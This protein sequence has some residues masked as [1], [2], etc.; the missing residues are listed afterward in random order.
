MVLS[1]AVVEAARAGN[2]ATV[3]QWL[4]AGGDA[5]ARC[6]T[7]GKTLLHF[8]A[9]N[10]LRPDEEER[11][12]CDIARLLLARG[13]EVDAIRIHSVFLKN[14]P[15]LSASLY[16]R[17]ELCRLLLEAGADP[18]YKREE[19]DFPLWVACENPATLRVL[20]SFGADPSQR[21]S[22]YQGTARAEMRLPEVNA[23]RGGFD[24]SFRLLR[25]AR[26][27]RPRLRAIFALRT[28]CDRGRA[29]PTSETLDGFVLMFFA[30]TS[31]PRTRAAW[32]RAPPGLPD[33]LAHLV[34]KFWL[35]DPPRR[36]EPA[37]E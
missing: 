20:L 4:Y 11:G 2:V 16:N 21:L 1:E 12:R 25:D 22:I 14:T 28:L 33:P 8:I 36:A 13:A 30:P 5:N 10:S 3:E 35:G 24:E 23:A 34:C 15:L 29:T 7:T 6:A 19:G 27:L 31:R 37:T 9:S 18:N 17:N 26:L 32:R